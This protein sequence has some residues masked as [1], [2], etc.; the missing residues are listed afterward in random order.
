MSTTEELLQLADHI[1]AA[2]VDEKIADDT[3]VVGLAERPDVASEPPHSVP[4]IKSS[5]HRGAWRL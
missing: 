2:G 1:G 4:T 3:P 5:G